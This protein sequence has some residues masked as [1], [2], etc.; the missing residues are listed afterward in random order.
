[1][2]V[3]LPPVR[4]AR[5]PCIRNHGACRGG[6]QVAYNANKANVRCVLVLFD[7]SKLVI[8]FT[9]VRRRGVVPKQ[10]LQILAYQSSIAGW[11]D[12]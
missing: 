12:E 6:H 11:L 1:M 5:G 9:L 8:V 2:T 3:C 7:V 4:E 10:G